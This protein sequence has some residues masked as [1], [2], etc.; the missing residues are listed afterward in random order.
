MKRLIIFG[1][2][3]ISLLFSPLI[4]NASSG[5][6]GKV[7]GTVLSYGAVQYPIVGAAIRLYF[8]A[9]STITNTVSGPDGTYQAVVAEGF[10]RI[11]CGGEGTVPQSVDSVYLV[12]GET[13]IVDFILKEFPYPASNV[14]VEINHHNNLPFITW[15]NRNLAFPD[16]NENARAGTRAFARYEVYRMLEGDELIPES[17]ALLYDN[18]L[19]PFCYDIGWQSI[20]TGSYRYAIISAYS[21]NA[22][23][24]AFSNLIWNGINVTVNIH[25]GMGGSSEG[26]VISFI[27]QDHNPEHRYDALAPFDGSVSFTDVWPGIYELN[28]FLDYHNPYSLSNISVYENLTINITLME[29]FMPPQ[30][31]YRPA[32]YTLCWFPPFVDYFTIYYE[33]FEDGIIPYGWTQECFD[34]TLLWTV[35][36]GSPSGFPDHAHSGVFNASFI[37]DSASTALIL[38]ELNLQ[39]AVLP[40]LSFWHAQAGDIVQD[41]LKVFYKTS[42]T[43]IWKPLSSYSYPSTWQ[44]EWLSLPSPSANYYIGF[45]GDAKPG[46]LGI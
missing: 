31:V 34:S 7:Q 37:G 38:P 36:T 2:F 24:P 12:G 43:A 40:K 8:Y 23:E 14:L 11:S 28:V 18:V 39:D 32:T 44:R 42:A 25:A 20:D 15:N 10:Y 35:Q 1:I 13:V 29:C 5:D 19:E 45:F 4:A 26:A 46:G 22:A 33:D 30:G 41:E 3:I 17:W 27:N 9:N 16:Y 6:R 21:Y